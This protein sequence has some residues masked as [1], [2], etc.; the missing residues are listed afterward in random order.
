MTDMP[1]M[2][3]L[4]N[5]MGG[6]AAAS[7]AAVELY[8]GG[9]GVARDQHA[10]SRRRPHRRHF[11]QRQPDRVRQAAGADPPLA[12]LL[13]SAAAQSRDP[14]RRAGARHADRLGHRCRPRHG[15][16]AVRALAAARADDDLA[17]RR[18]RH[19]GRDLALQ[20]AHRSSGRIRGLRARQR[21]DDHRGHGRGLGRHAA[22]AADGQGH[23]SFA[24]QRAVLGLRRYRRRD[25]RRRGQRQPEADRGERCRSDDGVR[26]ESHR[27]AWLWHGGRAGAAQGVGAMPGADRARRDMCASRFT[28][29]QGACRAT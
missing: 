24:R 25:H 16:G 4:Y 18:R 27:R 17:D 22:D 5:G 21:R 13:G 26:A 10:R 15:H 8:R 14:A 2:I 20:R 6:G 19:A 1:Q 12:A 28:R 3:A 23:E 7:I 11:L 9:A 29:W